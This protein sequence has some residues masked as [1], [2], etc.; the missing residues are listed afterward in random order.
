[1]GIGPQDFDAPRTKDQI[2]RMF[3]N[4]GYAYKA[5]KFEGVYQRAQEIVN[6]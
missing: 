5:G 3:S 4:I 2:R 1:M 6:I